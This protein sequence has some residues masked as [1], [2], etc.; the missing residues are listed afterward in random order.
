[1]SEIELAGTWAAL[2]PTQLQRQRIE[3]RVREW[4]DARESSL[5]AEWLALLKINPIA[6]LGFAAVAA[7]L[8]LIAT[9][10]SWMVFSVL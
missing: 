4:V 3:A 1:M 2:E 10:L 9:P 7:S 8:V 5:T 6:G